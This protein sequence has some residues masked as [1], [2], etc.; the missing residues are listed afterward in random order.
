MLELAWG[1]LLSVGIVY[2]LLAYF[3]GEDTDTQE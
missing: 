2:F 1:M 3:G